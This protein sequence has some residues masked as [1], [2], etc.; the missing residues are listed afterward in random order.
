MGP[1]P[2]GLF[3]KRAELALWSLLPVVRCLVQT[4]AAWGWGEGGGWSC[5]NLMCFVAL[6][7]MRR[8]IPSKWPCGWGG[9]GWREGAGGEEGRGAVADM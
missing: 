6:I 5:L 2:V 8:L 1:L 9:E 4:D 7:P 3:L